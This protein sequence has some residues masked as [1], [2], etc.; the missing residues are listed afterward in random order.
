MFGLATGGQHNVERSVGMLKEL[1]RIGFLDNA[2]N[3]AY[4]AQYL[5][6][7]FR[8]PDNIVSIQ[9]N[10][11]IVKESLLMG[12][13]GAVKLHTIWRDNELISIIVKGMS[14]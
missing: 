4:L 14:R 5:K 2:E 10:G 3:R 7:V 9:S 11:C 6:R 12:R 1:E 13:Y 8:T